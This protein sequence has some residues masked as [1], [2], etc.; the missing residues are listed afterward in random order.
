M[1]FVRL[2]FTKLLNKIG[3]TYDGLKRG[4]NAD[5][6]S[7]SHLMT[8]QE[9]K[10]FL[11]EINH[12][13]LIFKEKVIEGRENLNDIDALDDIALGRVW[14]GNT[15]LENGLI[16][17][18]GGLHDAIDVA[19]DKANIIADADI[20]ILE[21]PKQKSFSFLDLFS[22]NSQEMT[23]LCLLYTSPSPRD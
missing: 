2:N 21:Y 16:D 1:I 11:E 15:A 20:E 17:R 14:T 10:R 9:S 6:G 12:S 22:D 5:F 19:K 23:I 7:M 3:I 8:E 18:I 4:D 13:Y